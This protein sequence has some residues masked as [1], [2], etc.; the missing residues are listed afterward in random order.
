M[1]FRKRQGRRT[2]QK[3]VR[4]VPVEDEQETQSRIHGERV[5]S[6]EMDGIDIMDM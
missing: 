3:E 5:S 4:T 2:L 6:E 1:E